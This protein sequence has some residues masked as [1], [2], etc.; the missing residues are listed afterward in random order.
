MKNQLAQRSNDIRDFS[1]ED[2]YN[3]LKK[4]VWFYCSIDSYDYYVVYGKRANLRLDT[5]DLIILHHLLLMYKNMQS[6]YLI[7]QM[8]MIQFVLDNR[9]VF[10]FPFEHLLNLQ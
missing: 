1:T 3:K 5:D 6:Y 9:L 7:K 4:I 10:L 8:H 2:I